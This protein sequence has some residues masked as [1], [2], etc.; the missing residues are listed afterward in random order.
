MQSLI[1]GEDETDD[2]D[3]VSYQQPD[4][5]LMSMYTRYTPQVNL[6][7]GMQET[8]STCANIYIGQLKVLEEQRDS[9]K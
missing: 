3:I 1:T 7:K 2:S 9:K 6:M 5:S 4:L 8:I